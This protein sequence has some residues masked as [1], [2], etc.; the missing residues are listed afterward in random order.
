[1]TPYL[2]VYT[3]WFICWC[4]RRGGHLVSKAAFP[5]G[6]LRIIYRF[7][8][9]FCVQLTQIFLGLWFHFKVNMVSSVLD[10]FACGRKEQFS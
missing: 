3:D 1:M 7:L 8:S 6:F 5:A 9:G 4:G 2:V 10:V